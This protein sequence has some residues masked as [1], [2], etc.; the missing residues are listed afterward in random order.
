MPEEINPQDPQQGGVADP[1][2]DEALDAVE[3]TQEQGG[4]VVARAEEV[5]RSS[6]GS[7]I[8]VTG[9]VKPEE[10]IHSFLG[11]VEAHEVMVGDVVVYQ[12]NQAQADDVNRVFLRNS[13]HGLNI[14]VGGRHTAGQ[15][16]PLIVTKVNEDGTLN[17]QVLLDGN[18][19]IW[20][21]AVPEGETEGTWS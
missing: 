13:I 16:L 5:I 3:A 2:T 11:G 4:S 17:G 20:V 12:L 14:P 19:S 1:A 8:R 9:D 15:E 21:T 10:E 7:E 18:C 6:A